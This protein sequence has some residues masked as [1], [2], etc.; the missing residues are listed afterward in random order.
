MKLSDLMKIFGLQAKEEDNQVD[1]KDTKELNELLAAFDEKET[2]LIE[3]LDQIDELNKQ[4]EQFAEQKAAAEKAA[5]D[6][7]AQAHKEKMDARMAQLSAELG[8]DKAEKMLKI[9]EKM[10]DAEF[11]EVFGAQKE[12]VAKED[13]KLAEAGIDAKVQEDKKPVHFKTFIKKQGK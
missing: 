5:A 11:A 13:E 7:I 9:V 1:L 2:Q 8:D 12:L 10:D 3:A 6:A 4:L